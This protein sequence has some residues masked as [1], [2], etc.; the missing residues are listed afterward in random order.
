VGGKGWVVVVTGPLV[1]GIWGMVRELDE[2]RRPSLWLVSELPLLELP[3][4]FKSDLVRSQRLLVIEEHVAQGGVAQNLAFVLLAAGLAPQRFA[5][6][7]ALGYCSGR[8]GS[9]DF[10]RR[11]N[12]LDP[13]SILEFLAA[14]DI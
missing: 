12:G 14:E 9:Q 6:K 4:D 8:Y 3:E 1:G 13:D 11:E 5:S 10:H 2:S 7:T